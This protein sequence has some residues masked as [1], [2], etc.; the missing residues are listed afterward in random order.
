[1]QQDLDTPA[2]LSRLMPKAHPGRVPHQFD[3][4]RLVKELETIFAEFQRLIRAFD[5]DPE[6]EALRMKLGALKR[7]VSER[8]PAL[9]QPIGPAFMELEF[10]RPGIWC[11]FHQ[12]W[13]G[14]PRVIQGPTTWL[15]HLGKVRALALEALG[16]EVDRARIGAEYP[17]AAAI[18]PAPLGTLRAPVP[19][20]G[21]TNET[22]PHFTP[23]QLALRWGLDQSTVRR[24]F[25]DE[26]GVLRIP[27]LRRRGKRDYVSL[28]IPASV[29]ARVHE[30]RSRSLFKI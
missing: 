20:L 26:P 5:R 19:C 2:T 13:L 22:E 29:A 1:M 6:S 4:R 27:H 7:E 10:W 9:L 17:G 25:R 24:I 18:E 11:A 23:K 14:P 8:L 30:R 16:I 28:R 21:G 15:Q 3:F 12:I